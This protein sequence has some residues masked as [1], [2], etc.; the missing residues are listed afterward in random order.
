MRSCSDRYAQI[1]FL[2]LNDKYAEVESKGVFRMFG[3]LRSFKKV[4][5]FG[6]FERLYQAYIQLQALKYNLK[7]S[8]TASMVC[9]YIK[10]AFNTIFI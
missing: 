7:T 10:L 3:S 9:F 1:I 5:Q 8:A 4:Q 2:V 6:V